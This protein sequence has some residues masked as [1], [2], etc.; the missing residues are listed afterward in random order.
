MNEELDRAGE[1]F[2]RDVEPK[3]A[4]PL[5][6]LQR[7]RYGWPRAF[8]VSVFWLSMVAIVYILSGGC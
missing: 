6:G 7:E 1:A 3:P 4:T 2:E 5:E 8:A